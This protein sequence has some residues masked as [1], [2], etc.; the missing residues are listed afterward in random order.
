MKKWITVLAVLFIASC[1]VITC[2]LSLPQEEI[3]ETQ[4]L[5]LTK[6]LPVQKEETPTQGSSGMVDPSKEKD[7]TSI[8]KQQEEPTS[9]RV[10]LPLQTRVQE[11]GYYCVPACVQ[12]VFAYHGI[13]MSQETL[14]EELKTKPATGTEYVDLAI[15][16][17]QYIFHHASIDASLPGYQVATFKGNEPVQEV[18]DVLEQRVK[19]D[20]ETKDPVFVAIDVQ[21]MYPEL[22]RGNHI[23]IIVGY[24]YQPNSEELA[25]YYFIDPSY[26]VQDA[27]YGGLKKA[28]GEELV[29]AMLANEE[30]AYVW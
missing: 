1:G 9:H 23:V 26:L 4:H 6:E 20:I 17:N 27:T 30:P 25:A 29:K 14:A 8:V 19:Q 15:T 28:T 12:M 16:L 18:L 24:E 22:S 5:D 10:L 3:K 13:D 21:T 11:N 7:V 2:L